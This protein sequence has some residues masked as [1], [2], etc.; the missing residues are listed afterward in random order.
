LAS[1]VVF[2]R[3]DFRRQEVEKNGTIAWL[4]SVVIMM[5]ASWPLPSQNPRSVPDKSRNIVAQARTMA[6]FEMVA[7]E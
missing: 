3:P 6:I 4:I 2:V 5:H 7:C 1:I